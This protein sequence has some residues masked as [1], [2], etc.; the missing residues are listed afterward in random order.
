[1]AG[2]YHPAVFALGAG[3]P[4]VCVAYQHKAT[5]VMA[6]AGAADA[7]MQVDDVTPEAL[8]ALATSVFDDRAT[9][10]ERLRTVAPTLHQLSARTSDLAAGL[11]TGHD[12]E[13]RP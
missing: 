6:A 3:V 7:V 10:A 4:V 9:M 13:G 12:S 2:R 1:M 11:V 5:G 8:V